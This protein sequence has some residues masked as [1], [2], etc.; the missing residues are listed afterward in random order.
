M[1]Y[2]IAFNKMATG[3]IP[4]GD[5]RWSEFNDSFVNMEI[6]LVDIV[7][8][9]HSGHAFTTWHNGRRKTDNF[10]CAQHLALDFDTGDK[11]SS[12]THLLSNPF[13][14]AYAA[15][16]Y[17]TPSSSEDR[18]R[19]RVVFLLDELITDA[20]KYSAAMEFLVEQFDGADKACTDASRFFYGARGADI[21]YQ[22]NQLPMNQLR[23]WYRRWKDKQP[24]KR[25]SEKVVSMDAARAKRIEQTHYGDDKPTLADVEGMLSRINPWSIDYKQWVGVLAA[26]KREYGD[27]A[28]P[29]ATRWADGKDGEVEKE[30][31]KHLNPD[32]TGKQAGIGTIIYLARL[33]G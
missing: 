13:I 21:Y 7:Y 32:R 28:L 10:I 5:P 6:D 30:W 17:P 26:L 33:G 23:V 25:Q 22:F 19:S 11:R 14:A 16:I 4:Q 31:E 18:P 1:L 27:A 29:L 2:K 12:K 24:P 20:T 9:I 3:K 15:I 8:E